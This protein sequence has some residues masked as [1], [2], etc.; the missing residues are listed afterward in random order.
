MARTE[1]YSRGTCAL[2]TLGSPSARPNCVF[3]VHLL[4]SGHCGEG[5][6]V[7]GYY[8]A[9]TGRVVL[10]GCYTGYHPPRPQDWYCQ[11]PTNARTLVSAPTM[12]LRALSWALRTPWLPALRYTRLRPIRARFS[13]KYTK[14]SQNGKVS[15]KSHMRPGILPISKKGSISHDLE[16][17]R[18][19]LW[20]AFSDKE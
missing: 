7:G 10:G 20:P 15:T 2:S 5:V 3:G 18:F 1:R 11:G 6:R 4:R 9:G 19:P 14:V 16:F 13:L 17:L 12:A 8:R